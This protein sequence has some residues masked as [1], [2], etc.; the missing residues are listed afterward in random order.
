MTGTYSAADIERLTRAGGL[1]TGGNETGGDYVQRLHG[2]SYDLKAQGKTIFQ[3]YIPQE[4]EVP[5]E[6]Y[7][8]DANEITADTVA[9][10][11][12]KVEFLGD[13]EYK[14]RKLEDILGSNSGNGGGDGGKGN[15]GG[16]G[17][18]NGGGGDGGGG[19]GGNNNPD[20]TSYLKKENDTA[21]NLSLTGKTTFGSKDGTNPM[22]YYPKW[23]E[24]KGQ[25]VPAQSLDIFGGVIFQ[26]PNFVFWQQ[27]LDGKQYAFSLTYLVRCIEKLNNFLNMTRQTQ[28]PHI[29]Y[30][31]G[32]QD[33]LNVNEEN[34]NGV[35]AQFY[36]PV[37]FEEPVRFKMIQYDRF[38]GEEI[39]SKNAQIQMNAIAN[40]AYCFKNVY[41]KSTTSQNDNVQTKTIYFDEMVS[42]AKNVYLT[43]SDGE[44]RKLNSLPENVDAMIDRMN[45]IDELIP[46]LVKKFDA[47]AL[48]NFSFF[49]TPLDENGKPCLDKKRKDADEIG[50]AVDVVKDIEIQMLRIGNDAPLAKYLV[51]PDCVFSDNSRFY[52]QRDSMFYSLSHVQ[53]TLT[54]LVQY[55]DPTY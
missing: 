41:L 47:E 10:F 54:D 9:E 53:T 20:L 31:F 30:H 15:G 27:T 39:V 42:F 7:D 38:D 18:G 28:S 21:N 51:F 46:K 12:G 49:Y 11:K 24:F 1:G 35:V 16:D 33:F 34:T 50:R 37:Y 48:D 2:S 55:L 17:G 22:E 23:D 6:D 36:G 8:V 4:W 19:D 32:K 13:V 14:G 44:F 25:I 43:D 26:N 29:K 3:K 40:T 5:P 52:S 45:E